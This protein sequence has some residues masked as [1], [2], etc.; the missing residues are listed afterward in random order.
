MAQTTPPA[1]GSPD[2]AALAHRYADVMLA[3]GR[4]DGPGEGAAFSTMLDR[5]TLA[6]PERPDERLAYWL[7]EGAVGVRSIDRAWNASNPFHD[8]ALYDLLDRLADD[9]GD[10]R[11]RAA[12]DGALAWH[13]GHAQHPETGLVAWGEHLGWRLDTDEAVEHNYG[14]QRGDDPLYFNWGHLKHETEPFFSQWDRAARLDP[15]AFGRFADGY[16]DYQVYDHERGLHAHQTRWDRFAPDS[17]FVFPRTAGHG[18]YVWALAHQAADTPA[19]RAELE[20]RIALVA[21]TEVA[22]RHPESDAAPFLHPVNAPTYEGINDL[23][24]AYDVARAAEVE[25]LPDG[26]R[27]SLRA[28]AARSD[29]TVLALD[30]DPAGAGFVGKAD[31]ATLAP[32]SRVDALWCKKYP[33]YTVATMGLAFLARAEQLDLDADRRQHG[34]LE[35]DAPVAQGPVGAGEVGAGRRVV[36]VDVVAVGEHVLDQA[37]RVGRP[38]RLAHQQV[39][40]GHPL[41][42]LGRHV[43]DLGVG[44]ERPDELV[45]LG[46][47]RLGA[48][49]QQLAH[50]DGGRDVP[51]RAEGG[52]LDLVRE[53]R[54]PVPVLVG[55]HDHPHRQRL[56]PVLERADPVLGH[57]DQHEPARRRDG[58]RALHGGPDLAGPVGRRHVEGGPGVGPDDAVGA[59]A[60]AGLR[61][62]QGVG[63]GRV[64]GGAGPRRAAQRALGSQPP[65]ERADLGRVGLAGADERAVGDGRPPAVG[66]QALVAAERVREPRAG[67]G[68]RGPGGGG[69]QEQGEQADGHRSGGGTVPKYAHPV[70]SGLATARPLAGSSPTRARPPPC[71]PTRPRPTPTASRPPTARTGRRSR[72][73]TARPSSPTATRPRP[74]SSRPTARAW[75]RPAT[76]TSA[77]GSTTASS[78][79]RASRTATRPS[80]RTR[81]RPATTRRRRRPPV[82]R[83]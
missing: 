33:G 45:P 53:Q 31:L 70:P 68:R 78:R 44:R 3:H 34:V 74:P 12:A 11:Y 48:L 76:P 43:V 72:T 25:T 18:V 55:P 52:V 28:W 36:E 59:Q 22:R 81:R 61:P 26:L 57:V 35:P 75:P 62:A 2:Y 66:G 5:A 19:R 1:S 32:A 56:A 71:T 41:E 47:E 13:L 51:E 60:E 8:A 39:P 58:R 83:R 73:R 6:L 64:Q 21:R 7:D 15:A 17:G 37:Q 24:A 63:E 54:R 29:R 69:D 50:R 67:V 20:R 77:G 80:T 42:V 65:A 10:A 49:G 40:V 38:G 4:P 23:A 79:R 9:A 14:L 82:G 46:R 30:H 27:Q 16:W